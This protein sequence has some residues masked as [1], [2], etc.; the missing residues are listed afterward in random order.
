MTIF[1]ILVI[2]GTDPND[3]DRLIQWAKGSEISLTMAF[4]DSAAD[5]VGS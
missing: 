1:S 5:V 2:M 3:S 4:W